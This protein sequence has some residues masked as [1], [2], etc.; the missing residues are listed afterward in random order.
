[1]A[2]DIDL[3]ANLSRA[4]TQRLVKLIAAFED[5]NITEI[6]GDISKLTNQ[7]QVTNLK[8][9]ALTIEF[10]RA[11]HQ[12]FGNLPLNCQNAIR[13][14]LGFTPELRE[15]DKTKNLRKLELRTL[16]TLTPWFDYSRFDIDGF[17]NLPDWPNLRFLL[18][19]LDGEGHVRVSHMSITQD[20]NKTILPIFSTVRRTALDDTKVVHG[21]VLKARSEIYTIGQLAGRDGLRFTRMKLIEPFSPTNKR[22]VDLYGMRLGHSGENARS[23]SHILYGRQISTE[24]S[25]ELQ[26]GWLKTPGCQFAVDDNQL[27]EAVPDMERIRPFLRGVPTYSGLQPCFME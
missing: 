7:K 9:Q 10:K 12:R 8:R 18:M 15:T 5:T 20:S 6:T 23:F 25:V 3:D 21:V 13:Q 22:R 4:T 17:K 19:R 16:H 14:T 11:V 1:M 2:L 27:L 24:M 26:K